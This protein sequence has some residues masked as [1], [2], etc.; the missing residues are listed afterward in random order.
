MRSKTLPRSPATDQTPGAQRLNKLLAAA[1]YGSRRDCEQ[2]IVTGRVEVDGRTV[3]E[4]GTKVDP[5]ESVVKVDGSALKRFRPVYFALNKPSGV[6]CTNRDPSGRMLAVDFIPTRE[7]VFSV[8]RLD[9]ASEGLILLTNDGELAQRLAHPKYGVQKTYFVTVQ[10]EI[11]NEDMS[12]LRKGVYLSDGFARVDGIKVRRQRKGCAELEIVLSEGKNRE[13]RRVLARLGHKVM[14]LRRLAIGSLRLGTLPTGASRELSRE[15]VAGLYSISSASRKAG[16]KR[17]PRKPAMPLADGHDE[18]VAVIDNEFVAHIDVQP[19]ATGRVIA[20]DDDVLP[21]KG[22][23]PRGRSSRS[24]AAGGS[25]QP[26]TPTRKTHM[27]P[28]SKAAG[29]PPRSLSGRAGA[30]GDR[31]GRPSSAGKPPR[32]A[33]GRSQSSGRTRGPK[34]R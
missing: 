23:P 29:K 25:A 28:G 15:E 2:L 11:T 30:T 26:S 7:R 18:P 5:A 21:S 10:G 24:P 33:A 22:K 3:T 27:R 8:G 4:L 14:A 17:K 31:N 9:R 34:K 20:F 32:K 6:L 19:S 12:N 13:I 1:G 16:R